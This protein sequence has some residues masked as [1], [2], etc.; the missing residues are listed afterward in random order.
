MSIWEEMEHSRMAAFDINDGRISEEDPDMFKFYTK[1]DALEDAVLFPEET[2][3]GKAKGLF[4]SRKVAV[5]QF[6]RTGPDWDR[7]IH[8]YETD[9]EQY[10]SDD[11]ESWENMSEKDEEENSKSNSEAGCGENG[12]ECSRMD[13]ASRSH[14]PSLMERLD[15]GLTEKEKQDRSVM[16]GWVCENPPGRDVEKDFYTFL[17]R[18][19][20]K[21]WP[22]DNIHRIC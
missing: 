9:E 3:N 14:L 5:D 6:L 8:D 1:A 12:I 16:K 4:R 18:E 21:G 22:Y 2:E 19:K 13:D 11:S 7:F 10:D 15:S 20:S 17:D